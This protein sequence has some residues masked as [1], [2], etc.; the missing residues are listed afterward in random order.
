MPWKDD[1]RRNKYGGW[2]RLKDSS[3]TVGNNTFTN[4]YVTGVT[5]VFGNKSSVHE[6]ATE[7]EALRLKDNIFSED[8]ISVKQSKEEAN[9]QNN[10]EKIKEKRAELEKKERDVRKAKNK[11]ERDKAKKERRK[12][13]FELKLLVEGPQV[14][15]EK[16]LLGNSVY[17]ERKIS[18]SGNFYDVRIDE[19]K[20]NDIRRNKKSGRR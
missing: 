6:F 2:F 9:I 11:K 13:E 3:Y 4:G 18:T 1:W 17:Y 15:E 10:E 5:R 16:D 12:A 20:Y 19:K 8:K 14:Y 7:D